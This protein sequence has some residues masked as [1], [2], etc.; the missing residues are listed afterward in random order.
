MR[1]VTLITLL[2]LGSIAYGQ[3][4]TYTKKHGSIKIKKAYSEA[5]HYTRIAGVLDGDITS[6]QLCNP[7][8]IYTIYP[9]DIQSF[10]LDCSYL[11]SDA[12]VTT[13]GH[14]L[15]DEMC[16]IV[17]VL[18]DHTV[19]YFTDIIALDQKGNSVRLNSLRFII[20]N[21]KN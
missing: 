15:S 19:V 6:A 17:S 14:V 2:C 9:Y 10:K 20:R 12:K 13:S 8:G 5:D 16:K 3:D 18:P 1:L 11:K 4:T 7:D 21:K